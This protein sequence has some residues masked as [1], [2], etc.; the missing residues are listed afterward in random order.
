MNARS[1]LRIGC[2]AAI[3]ILMALS[4]SGCIGAAIRAA[5]TDETTPKQFAANAGLISGGKARVWVYCVEGSPTAMNTLGVSDVV[6]FNETGR[7]YAGNSFI[8]FDTA[9]G[10]YTITTGGSRKTFGIYPGR[11]RKEAQFE[12][13]SEYFIR[14]RY[15]APT[16]SH[17]KPLSIDI[18]EK[19]TAESEM[20]GLKYYKPGAKAYPMKKE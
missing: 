4:F 6:T 11:I 13:G 17:G 2:T 15:D 9:G 3:G 19:A 7:Y 12:P 16:F 18:V 10:A 8:A 1:L 20:Q 14:I 5:E